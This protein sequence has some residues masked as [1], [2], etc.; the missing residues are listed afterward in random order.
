MSQGSPN[1]K[2]WFLG[3][4]VVPVDCLR[5]DRQTDRMTTVGTLLGF[6]DVSLQRIIKDRS[7][8][9]ELRIIGF[10]SALLSAT[11]GMFCQQMTHISR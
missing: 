4:K 10:I 3:Q 2:I 6:Q 1:P 5:T 9:H 7:N 11:S 8:Y